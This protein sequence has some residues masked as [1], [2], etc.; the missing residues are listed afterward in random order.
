MLE[1]I[2]EFAAE[3]RT[4]M[5]DAEGIELGYRSFFLQL[6]RA[7]EVGERGPEQTAW[8]NRLEE[9]I[10]NLRAVLDASRRRGNHLEEL[11]LAVLLKR[12]WHVRS[13]LQEGRRRI[14]EALSSAPE[15]D[16]VLRARAL[17][18]VAYCIGQMS[19]DPAVAAELTEQA[20]AFYRDSGDTA[21]VARMTLDLGVAADLGG[22]ARRAGELY[23]RARTL[24]RE[25]GDLR[26]A[27][28]A[29][30]NLA[31]LAF[32]QADYAVAVERAER[33]VA[34]AQATGDPSN[35]Q[36]ANVLLA[37]V[38][39]GAGRNEEARELGLR[40]LVGTAESGVYSVARDALE[41]LAIVSV[42]TGD[43]GR[44]AVLAGLAERLRVETAEPRQRSGEAFIP[45]GPR[46]GG[47]G[48]R[49]QALTV[50]RWHE[51]RG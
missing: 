5:P 13:H 12:F 10:D 45:S 21:G 20:L 31:N 18:A 16:G 50:R 49:R 48:T 25:A 14:E 43:E 35:V 42:S 33:S 15:A 8:W 23:E 17:A 2:R 27:Y 30:H 3:L 22:D 34:A 51:G 1:T 40:V 46:A 24:A 9:E 4:A 29:A 28:F 32:Q 41:L 7:A 39:A 47:A 11:E 19:G 6:A 36:T 38:L 26:Y 44:G 37:Y